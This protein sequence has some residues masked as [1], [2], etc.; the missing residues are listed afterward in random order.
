M[1]WYHP[2]EHGKS[3]TEQTPKIDDS[4]SLRSYQLPIVPKLLVKTHEMADLILCRSYIGNHQY[5]CMFI[6]ESDNC[7]SQRTVLHITPLHPLALIFFLDLLLCTPWALGWDYDGVY[8][9]EGT[10]SH[11][12]P[13]P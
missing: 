8:D 11:S 13:A 10:H 1:V 2:V 3:S 12:F 5:G 9:G 4:L 7:H 6:S